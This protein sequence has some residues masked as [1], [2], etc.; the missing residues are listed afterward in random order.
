MKPQIKILL[1]IAGTVMIGIIALVCL[2]LWWM[3]VE[4]KKRLNKQT[5]KARAARWAPKLTPETIDTKVEVIESKLNV[6]Q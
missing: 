2:P 6:V 3:H 1:A 4:E 5:A